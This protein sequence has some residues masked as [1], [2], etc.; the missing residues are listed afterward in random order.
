MTPFFPPRRQRGPV[1]LVAGAFGFWLF[2][3]AAF[4]AALPDRITS[5]DQ[6]ERLAW[7]GD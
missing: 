7:V 3:V 6:P 4:I 2:V 5:P 1:L